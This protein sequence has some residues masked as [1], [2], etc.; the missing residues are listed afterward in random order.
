MGSKIKSQLRFG[1]WPE[2]R[3]PAPHHVGLTVAAKRLAEATIE[4][5]GRLGVIVTLEDGRARFR[6]VKVLPPAARRIIETH[7]DLIEAFLRERNS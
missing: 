7:A 1:L 5:L 2:T 4:E 3:E 6:A